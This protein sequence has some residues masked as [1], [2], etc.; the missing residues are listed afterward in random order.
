M[1]RFPSASQSCKFIFLL[2]LLLFVLPRKTRIPRSRHY[3]VFFPTADGSEMLHHLEPHS[4]QGRRGR[5][6]R[7]LIDPFIRSHPSA[8]VNPPHSSRDSMCLTIV[9]SRVGAP[10][11]EQVIVSLP[12]FHGFDSKFLS[13]SAGCVRVCWKGTSPSTVCKGVAWGL[14]VSAIARQ[15]SMHLMLAK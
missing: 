1:S 3:C 6:R 11:E 12:L 14:G 15:I 10:R 9:R 8:S 13:A 5:R 7:D 4:T 2:Q